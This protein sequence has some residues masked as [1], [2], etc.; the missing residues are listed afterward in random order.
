MRFLEQRDRAARL[1]PR[2]QGGRAVGRAR[3]ASASP[4]RASSCSRSSRGSSQRAQADGSL[5]PD[6][7]ATDMPL[8]QLMLGSLSEC[9]RDVE[10]EVW[11]RY[12]GIVTDGLRTRR[13]EPTALPPLPELPAERPLGTVA[14]RFPAASATPDRVH[15]KRPGGLV[16]RG[17]ERVAEPDELSDGRRETWSRSERGR[18]RENGPSRRHI[19]AVNEAAR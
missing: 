5:R 19:S 4:A 9:T 7:A 13:D 1:R 6:V 14:A 15:P 2:L 12:L 11:R 10:P 16:A 3:P 17:G 18:N 8:L